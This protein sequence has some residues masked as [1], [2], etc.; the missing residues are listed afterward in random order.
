MNIYAKL[1]LG[2]INRVTDFVRYIYV[3]IKF[4]V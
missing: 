1:I 2:E 4:C 3:K